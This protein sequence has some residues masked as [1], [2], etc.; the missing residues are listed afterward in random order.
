MATWQEQGIKP[1]VIMVDPP[2]KGLTQSLIESATKMQPQKS[3]M[4]AVIRQL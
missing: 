4:S 1:D 2:R 3:F